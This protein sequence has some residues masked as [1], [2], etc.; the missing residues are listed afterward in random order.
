MVAYAGF[1]PGNPS[2]PT[3]CTRA[4]AGLVRTVGADSSGVGHA[5]WVGFMRAGWIGV[6]HG[7]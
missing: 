3:L 1:R 2:C 6:V 5:R 7:S 4:H